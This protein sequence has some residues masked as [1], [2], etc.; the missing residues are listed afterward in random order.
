MKAIVYKSYL[1]KAPGVTGSFLLG[2]G[3]AVEFWPLPPSDDPGEV[4]TAGCFFLAG[5]AECDRGDEDEEA[6][7]C[8]S[9]RRH[10]G[11]TPGLGEE[12]EEA[13]GEMTGDWRRSCCCCCWRCLAGL[14]LL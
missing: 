1:C 9:R 4:A 5:E 12:G 14:W 11:L 6:A 3:V 8:A 2:E 13:P 7:G 10:R